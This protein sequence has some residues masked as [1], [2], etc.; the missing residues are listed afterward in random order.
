MKALSKKATIA[1]VL[2]GSNLFIISFQSPRSARKKVNPMSE[3]FYLANCEWLKWT[4]EQS[5]RQRE[6]RMKKMIKKQKIELME[7]NRELLA[8][9]DEEQ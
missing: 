6:K 3:L 1:K 2:R 5:K 4:K 7:M 9:H 8:L